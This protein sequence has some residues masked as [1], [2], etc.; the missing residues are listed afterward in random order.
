MLSQEFHDFNELKRYKDSEKHSTLALSSELGLNDSNSLNILG[1]SDIR[2]DNPDSPWQLTV[3]ARKT[4]STEAV[5]REHPILRLDEQQHCCLAGA[6]VPRSGRI[7]HAFDPQ[8]RIR[9]D[10]VHLADPQSPWVA[11]IEHVP[12]TFSSPYTDVKG[13]SDALLQQSG[14]DVPRSILLWSSKSHFTTPEVEKKL[15]QIP[16][17]Y[18]LDGQEPSYT[19]Q[20]VK[21]FVES[22][23]FN[24]IGERG[25]VAKPIFG[26]GGKGVEI[27][28]SSAPAFP[29][30][31]FARE[32]HDRVIA[33]ENVLLQDQVISHD[34]FQSQ[35]AGH[36]SADPQNASIRAFVNPDEKQHP[37]TSGSLARVGPKNRAVNL[38]LGAHPMITE[39]FIAQL[40][41]QYSNPT[42][43]PAF[44]SLPER[45]NKAGKN[46]GHSVQRKFS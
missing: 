1:G 10:Y 31:S 17:A 20:L 21:G 5:F 36:E 3:A 26:Y 39:K 28:D 15:T 38:S 4:P 22:G 2:D 42:L 27:T 43:E 7:V 33:G 37:R 8:C 32:L 46:A 13:I 44:H 16:F 24:D 41:D 45:I 11:N 12:H 9:L 19:E 29:F 6:F 30:P 25:V 23:K 18:Q 14:V 34:F 40:R 35:K